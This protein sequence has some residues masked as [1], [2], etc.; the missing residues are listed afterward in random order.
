[1]FA[2]IG[3]DKDSQDRDWTARYYTMSK[4]EKS[5][6]EPGDTISFTPT[7]PAAMGTPR[8][9]IVNQKDLNELNIKNA[10]RLAQEAEIDQG[11]QIVE[12]SDLEA[13][14]ST[15]FSINEK[16]QTITQVWNRKDG[17]KPPQ[18]S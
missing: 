16:T 12:T 18:Q 5:G 8:P 4:Q 14:D 3:N 13:S 1:M 15:A 10:Q 7:G 11:K 17:R 9:L 2:Q 6:Y